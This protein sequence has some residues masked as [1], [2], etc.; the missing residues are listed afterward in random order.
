MIVCRILC[1][2]SKLSWSFQANDHNHIEYKNLFLK[3]LKTKIL[4]NIN[5]KVWTVTITGKPQNKLVS[6]WRKTRSFWLFSWQLHE[7]LCLTFN[8]YKICLSALL[9]LCG[10][11]KKN[12]GP[13]YS[14]IILMTQNCRRL[15]NANKM[16][17]LIGNKNKKVGMSKFM[18]AL[19]ENYLTQDKNIEWFGNYVF[20][21]T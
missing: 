4:M 13:S 21:S 10:D 15:N 8:I 20:T 2:Q 1:C 19:Q 12:P 14:E 17:Q 9:M 7:S 5:L 18:S 16:R 6:G 11:V 3:F